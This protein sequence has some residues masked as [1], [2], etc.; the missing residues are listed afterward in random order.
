MFQANDRPALIIGNGPS[1]DQFDPSLL[2]RCE[3]YGCNHIGKKFAEWG[4][5]TDHIVITDSFRIREIGR[6]YEKFPGR[7]YIGDE[8][9][10]EPP[11]SAIRRIVNR[12]FQP[13]RQ[14][15]RRSFPKWT[16]LRRLKFNKYLHPSVF[17]KLRFTFELEKGLNF[18][19]SV[20]IS[21][22]QIA[23][24]NGHKRILLTG[25]DSSYPTRKA[26]FHGMESGVSYVNNSFVENPRIFMEPV[27]VALQIHLEDLGVEL[28]DCTPGG[29]LRFISKGDL[30]QLGG[31]G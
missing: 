18:G 1:V 25:V 11:V 21:A 24:I 5:G 12:D 23:V 20:V 2:T 22:I 28:I 30:S 16:F 29:K 15:P 8:N 14:I 7:V 31:R 27:L 17:D 13:L 9:Y 4:R 19:Y 6:A 3:S 10:I 26:Y